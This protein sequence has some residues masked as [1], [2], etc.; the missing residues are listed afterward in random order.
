MTGEIQLL[1]IC[2]TVLKFCPASNHCHIFKNY[3]HTESSEFH[4]TLENKRLVRRTKPK[5]KGAK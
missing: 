1:S 3:S 2:N 5:D 4:N